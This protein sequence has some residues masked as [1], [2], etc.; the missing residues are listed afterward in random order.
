MAKN[1]AKSIRLS[2]E[3]YDYINQYRGNGFNEK[4][5]NIILDYQAK[6]KEIQEKIKREEKALARWTE[7]LHQAVDKVYALEAVIYKV[8]VCLRNVSDLEEDLKALA[9]GDAEN[10]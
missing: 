9:G 8:G 10:E 2:Q 5:E 6:E 1:I 3:V 7:R 4:F